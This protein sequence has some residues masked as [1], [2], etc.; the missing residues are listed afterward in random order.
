MEKKI[1]TFLF[2]LYIV[3]LIL[4]VI[5]KFNGSFE[6]IIELHQNIKE[7]EQYGARNINIVL[8]RSMST[9]LENITEP[10]AF[11]NIIGNII[12]FIPLGF[13]ISAFFKQ[14]FLR[15]NLTCVAIIFMIEVA[16]FI[17]KIGFFDVDDIIL[18]LFGCLLG[19]SI[20]FIFHKIDIF[21]R[22]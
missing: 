21:K 13:L 17:F 20:Q 4:F 8:F 14:S 7:S 22:T 3:S 9:Y 6:Q 16:Q 5:L 10:Y 12:A 2:I 18:G 19:F 1:Y 11:F 15:T